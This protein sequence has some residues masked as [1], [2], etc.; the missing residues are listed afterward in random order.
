LF[1]ADAFLVAAFL[2]LLELLG[3]SEDEGLRFARRFIQPA[4]GR[5]RA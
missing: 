4:K 3:L 2:L 5:L 1:F